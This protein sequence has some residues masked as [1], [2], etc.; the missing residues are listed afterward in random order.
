MRSGAVKSLLVLEG[1]PAY[2]APVDLD[3]GAAENVMVFHH[4]L[5]RDE[6]AAMS[7]W[8]MRPRTGSSPGAT[9]APGTVRSTSP[10]R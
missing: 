9:R 2:D 10:S 5:Y 4:G 3:F 6:T 8:H 1:N 7:D